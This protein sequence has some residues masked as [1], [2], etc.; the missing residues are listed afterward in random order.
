MYNTRKSSVDMINFKDYY[1]AMIPR[2][3]PIHYSP[4]VIEKK[5]S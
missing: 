1:G 5:K 4:K 2:P 3:D